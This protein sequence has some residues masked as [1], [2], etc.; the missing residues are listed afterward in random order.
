MENAENMLFSA[1]VV[2]LSDM[3]M[4]LTSIPMNSR[5]RGHLL[6]FIK[7]YLDGIF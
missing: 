4:Q 1:A 3:E 6:T 5:G 2:V 7:G